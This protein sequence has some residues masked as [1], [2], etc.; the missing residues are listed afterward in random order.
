MT[1]QIRFIVF[2]LTKNKLSTKET[3]YSIIKVLITAAKRFDCQ[4]CHRSYSNKYNL[5]KHM[6]VHD[7][8]KAFK[9]DVCLKAFPSKS[10]L[11]THYRTHTGKSHLLVKFV[12]K[13]LL[14]KLY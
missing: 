7:D 8:S 11:E 5:N 9:C 12:I 10:H 4:V 3:F 2:K 1:F 13:N 14:K 6:K